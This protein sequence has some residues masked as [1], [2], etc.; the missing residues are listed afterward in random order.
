MRRPALLPARPVVRLLRLGPLA[1]AIVA[2]GF[3]TTGANRTVG[4]IAD[5]RRMH[6]AA[7][8]VGALASAR[9]KLTPQPGIATEA[10]APGAGPADTDGARGIG[11][12]DQR[13]QDQRKGDS[14]WLRQK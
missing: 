11:L 6:A 7:L 14:K 1:F 9:F 12:P 13:D 8:R 4:E 2:E 10:G 3:P 5:L